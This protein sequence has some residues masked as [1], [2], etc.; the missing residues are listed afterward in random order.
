M[1]T[2]IVNNFCDNIQKVRLFNC[3]ID[4]QNIELEK[5]TDISFKVYEPGFS[6]PILIKTSDNKDFSLESE[7]A[8]FPKNVISFNISAL[9]LKNI[10]PNPSLSDRIREYRLIAKK[11]GI[12]CLLSQG[13][14]YV[15][16]KMVGR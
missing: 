8:G 12:C 14:F 4:S 1:P 10:L 5:Y 16:D 7:Y 15:E 3:H 2:I 11:D 9:D 6:N 13:C